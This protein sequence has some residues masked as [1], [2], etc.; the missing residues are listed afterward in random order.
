LLACNYNVEE[1]SINNHLE[2]ILPV[3]SNQL[4][5]EVLYIKNSPIYQTHKLLNDVLVKRD[6]NS[7]YFGFTLIDDKKNKKNWFFKKNVDGEIVHNVITSLSFNNSC[8]AGELSSFTGEYTIYNKYNEILYYG[9]Y[10]KGKLVY[11][12]IHNSISEK[13]T[14]WQGFAECMEDWFDNLSTFL[15]WGCGTACGACAWSGGTVFGGCLGCG[16]CLQDGFAQCHMH[17]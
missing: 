11:L 12:H 7:I 17:L 1:E 6:E 9:S 10:N 15:R 16:I 13:S 5:N 4:Y 2:Y 14:D 8:N 3:E